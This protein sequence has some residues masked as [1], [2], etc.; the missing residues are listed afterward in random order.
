MAFKDPEEITVAVEETEWQI[1]LR[2]V[3]CN[4]LVCLAVWLALV[5]EDIGSC[6]HL[7]MTR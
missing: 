6:R 3:G 5:A 2:A 4:W 1:F 7:P